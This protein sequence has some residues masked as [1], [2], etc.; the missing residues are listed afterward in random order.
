MLTEL[1]CTITAAAA[2]SLVPYVPMLH[3]DVDVIEL[4]HVFDGDGRH[5]LSQ[6][7]FW[8]VH[9]RSATE[10]VVAWRLAKS[11]QPQPLRDVQQGGCLLL[12]R[13]GEHL[14][15]VRG[16]RYRETWTQYDPEIDDR[17]VLPQH[18][19]RELA[20]IEPPASVAAER[21]LRR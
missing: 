7:I 15:L 11:G 17:R 19:R 6:L 1:L 13:D 18:R 21:A 3:D 4:N 20:R 8:E 10:N 2:V 14:R 9:A 5:V 16:K 12:F